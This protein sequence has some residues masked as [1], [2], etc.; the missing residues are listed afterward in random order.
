[1]LKI[2]KTI[3]EA[4]KY[5]KDTKCFNL[6]IQDANIRVELFVNC[7]K[8]TDLTNALK[9]GKECKQITVTYS[10]LTPEDFCIELQNKYL[11]P[12]KKDLEDL[13][14]EIKN[15]KIFDLQDAGFEVYTKELKSIDIFSPFADIKPIKLPKNG[16]WT[17]S[18]VIKAILSGQIY[19][20]VVNGI[21][22][23]DYT[24]DNA[25]HCH[26]G[27]NVDLMEIAQKLTESN[28]GWAV[29]F[30]EEENGNIALNVD[31]CT[32]NC[33]TLY[34]NIDSRKDNIEYVENTQDQT[35][36]IDNVI[37]STI[38]KTNIDTNS[39]VVNLFAYKKQKQENKQQLF[40]N[41]L[42]C[43]SLDQFKNIIENYLKYT[44]KKHIYIEDSLTNTKLLDKLEILCQGNLIKMIEC[45]DI[46]D[47]FMINEDIQEK[48]LRDE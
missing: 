41:L 5:N 18:H 45:I 33:N 36:I 29:R 37:P 46:V 47:Y 48:K 3:K 13:I 7:L 25:V 32:F 26:K 14:H 10:E 27:E 17:K 2:Y 6:Y 31:C 22:T 35:A 23:D 42:S 28:G 20:G 4:A 34:F 24:Y 38:A 30:K 40:K 11:N 9:R 15:L 1:M 19:G 43:N 39:K 21:Y 44:K 8:I 16:K 12:S